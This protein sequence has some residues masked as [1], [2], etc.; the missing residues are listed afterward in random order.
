MDLFQYQS[1]QP[2]YWRMGTFCSNLT[3]VEVNSLISDTKK[4]HKLIMKISDAVWQMP[5]ILFTEEF[6]LQLR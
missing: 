3:K 5:W 2:L 1:N 4:V 6:F